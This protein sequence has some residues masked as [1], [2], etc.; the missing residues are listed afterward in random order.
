MEFTE[1]NK[2]SN[3]FSS[4]EGFC[5]TSYWPS[6]IKSDDMLVFCMGFVFVFAHVLV[7]Y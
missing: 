2:F 7:D 3:P 1:G 5:L 6:D 4:F